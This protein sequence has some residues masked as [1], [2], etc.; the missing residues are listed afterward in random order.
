MAGVSLTPA[1]QVPPSPQK[2]VRICTTPLAA[3]RK[4]P[5]CQNLEE[6]FGRF[7]LQRE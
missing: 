4:Q 1:T 7:V 5:G 6:R 3:K 2:K